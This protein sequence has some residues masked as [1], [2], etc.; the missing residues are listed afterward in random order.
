[1]MTRFHL[2]Q[3]NKAIS[4]HETL[5]QV[6]QLKHL[7]LIHYVRQITATHMLV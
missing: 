5:K 4:D 1:M 6:L 7:C 3:S 2:G